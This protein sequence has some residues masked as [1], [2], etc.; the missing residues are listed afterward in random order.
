MR[1]CN[2]VRLFASTDFSI[3]REMSL[4]NIL[5]D[6]KFSLKM[7]LTVNVMWQQGNLH[8]PNSPIQF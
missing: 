6:W 4:D 2:M 5:T 1:C 7:R 3:E 8:S